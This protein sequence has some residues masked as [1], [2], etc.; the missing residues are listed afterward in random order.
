MC[1]AMSINT[2]AWSVVGMMSIMVCSANVQAQEQAFP[3]CTIDAAPRTT[4]LEHYAA[5]HLAIAEANFERAH[6]QFAD[7]LALCMDDEVIW[8]LAR[9][10][11][12]L[13]KPDDAARLDETWR[14]QR[15]LHGLSLDAP[16]KPAWSVPQTGALASASRSLE[17]ADA[18]QRTANS[19]T[20]PIPLPSVY[21]H[22]DSITTIHV[23]A[24]PRAA[25]LAR[26]S[27]QIAPAAGA[28]L[29]LSD[30]TFLGNAPLEEVMIPARTDIVLVL[31]VN[32]EQVL[33]RTVRAEPRT[34]QR[35]FITVPK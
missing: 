16:K 34:H 1:G 20:Y 19:G 24:F 29:W 4:F 13:G 22:A 21:K 9:V 2:A 7:A 14:A 17:L 8:F 23:G 12:R 31:K 15:E 30:G 33:V 27:V 35:L 10:N 25:S 11:E 6:T 26:L 28:S 3:R 5:G 18:E 32:S